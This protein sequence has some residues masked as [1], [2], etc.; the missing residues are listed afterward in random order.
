MVQLNSYLSGKIATT[1]GHSHKLLKYLILYSYYFVPTKYK[2]FEIQGSSFHF[3]LIAVCG[4]MF[5]C[6]KMSKITKGRE[7]KELPTLQN[8]KIKVT[9]PRDYSKVNETIKKAIQCVT[10]Y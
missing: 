7:V 3:L 5:F 4:F 1:I 8:M 10:C 9:S 2:L 6:L